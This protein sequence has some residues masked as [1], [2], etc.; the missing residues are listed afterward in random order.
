MNNKSINSQ[1]TVGALMT[2][3]QKVSSTETENSAKFRKVSYDEVYRLFDNYGE[4]FGDDEDNRIDLGNGVYVQITDR[5][6]IW[7][8]GIET[9]DGNFQYTIDEFGGFLVSLLAGEEDYIDHLTH[10]LNEYI[11]DVNSTKV[12]EAA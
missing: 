6:D 5:G 4:W 2:G 9:S 10:V 8:V 3:A 11:D 7:D 1:E 12:V